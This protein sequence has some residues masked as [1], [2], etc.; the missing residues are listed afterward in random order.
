MRCLVLGGG[1]FIGSNLCEALLASG[2]Q[3]KVFERP[4]LRI[5]GIEGQA[6]QD[7]IVAGMEWMEGD[8]A[9]PIDV[10]PAVAGVDVIFHLVCTTL[11]KSSN[12]N[13]AYDIESNVIS[14]VRLLDAAKGFKV[15]KI[16]FISSGGTVYGIPQ[17]VPLHESLEAPHKHPE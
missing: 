17:K 2:Y 11:P 15:R 10:Q 3:V 12:D 13:P 8:F 16:I 6:G 4:R 7:G 14:T 1:G 5:D 9:N